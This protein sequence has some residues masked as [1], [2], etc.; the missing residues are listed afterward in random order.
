MIIFRLFWVLTV[1]LAKTFFLVSFS[2]VAIVFASNA[3]SQIQDRFHGQSFDQVS[4][5][6]ED[7]ARDQVAGLSDRIPALGGLAQVDYSHIGERL[8]RFKPRSNS[9]YRF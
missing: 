6:M 4:V 9:A 7:F 5:A 2:F 1:G 8:A 3:F